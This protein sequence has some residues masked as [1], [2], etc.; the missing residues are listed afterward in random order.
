MGETE[1]CRDGGSNP[2]CYKNSPLSGAVFV[3]DSFNGVFVN[4]FLPVGMGPSSIR[5]NFLSSKKRI[6][7][8]FR[9][10][11]RF[12]GIRNNWRA[13]CEVSDDR[14][15]RV[16]FT[17][18]DLVDLIRHDDDRLLVLAQECQHFEVIF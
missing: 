4:L 10:L 14:H 2:V 5:K 1:S 15:A 17:A 13:V 3:L 18:R 12:R 16:V 6:H 9:A 8:F 7:Q 11:P